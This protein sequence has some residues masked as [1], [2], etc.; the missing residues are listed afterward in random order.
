MVYGIRYTVYAILRK[1]EIILLRL[2]VIALI[3]NAHLHLH[4]DL[5][6]HLDADLDTRT[7][8]VM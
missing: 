3:T 1:A 8:A 2:F 4:L 7:H 5:R 6:L